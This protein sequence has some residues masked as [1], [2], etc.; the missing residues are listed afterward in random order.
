MEHETLTPGMINDKCA[1]LFMSNV[2]WLSRILV[3]LVMCALLL[4][5]Y[6]TYAPS[7]R[8]VVGRLIHGALVA[9][10]EKARSGGSGERRKI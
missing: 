6:S 5:F 7:S 4:Y 2:P 8:Q 1:K 9:A 3:S 10:E